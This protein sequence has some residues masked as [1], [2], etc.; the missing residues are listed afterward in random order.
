MDI[1]IERDTPLT[2]KNDVPVPA[3]KPL[4]IQHSARG[5]L[6]LALVAVP[7]VI[8]ANAARPAGGEA[9]G[10]D[11]LDLCVVAYC[12]AVLYWAL[13]RWHKCVAFVKRVTR[14][15]SS[16][17]MFVRFD[18]SFVCYGMRGRWEITFAWDVFEEV[19]LKESGLRLANRNALLVVER[20][21]FSEEQARELSDFLQQREA[22]GQAP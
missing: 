9:V 16:A 2:Y 20:S 13:H 6:V 19:R 12:V 8:L 17:T 4:F 14:G 15:L 18:E 1:L 3:G 11:L 21:A 10:Y 7:L 22:G 5:W